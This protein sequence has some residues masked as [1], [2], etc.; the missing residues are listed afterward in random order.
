MFVSKTRGR[1]C[2]AQQNRSS[3][4]LLAAVAA[5]LVVPVATAGVASAGFS[6]DVVGDW[7]ALDTK[8]RGG[9]VEL[10]SRCCGVA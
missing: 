6:E 9:S 4:A 10:D 1:H 7:A 8:H 2:A 5:A 3:W